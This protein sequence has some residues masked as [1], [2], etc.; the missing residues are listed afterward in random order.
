MMRVPT[1]R[2]RDGPDVDA[3]PQRRRIDGLQETGKVKAMSYVSYGTGQYRVSHEAEDAERARQQ[4]ERDEQ[5]AEVR[6]NHLARQAA[7]KEAEARATAETI[8]RSL[9][10]DKR[11]EMNFYLARNPGTTAS[12]FE[13][14]AWPHLRE[15]I[16]EQRKADVAEQTYQS[17]KRSG[18]YQPW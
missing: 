4:A 5:R 15:N 6:K 3:T 12:D 13:K 2:A 16:L 10:D 11:R 18:Q 17:M 14:D 9:S 1:Y 7:A 8:E